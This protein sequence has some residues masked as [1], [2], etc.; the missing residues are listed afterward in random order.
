MKIYKSVL[1]K[2]DTKTRRGKKMSKEISAVLNMRK[3]KTFVGGFNVLAHNLRLKLMTNLKENINQNLSHFNVYID[4]KDKEDFNTRYN[5]KI[6]NANLKRKIQKNASRIIEFVF[7]FSHLYSEGWQKIPALKKK[8]DN[9]FKDCIEFIHSEYGDIIV[10]STIHYD[11]F[12]PH[13]HI[14]CIPLIQIKNGEGL[15]FSSSEFMGGRFGMKNLH[16]NFHKKVGKNYGLARGVEDSITS[17]SDLKRYKAIE[18]KKLNE[19]EET[20]RA[21]KKELDNIEIHRREIE[22]N[23]TASEHLR[24]R[25]V[26]IHSDNFKRTATLIKKEEEFKKFEKLVSGQTPDIPILKPKMNE[27][28]SIS[29]RNKVQE[30]VNSAFKGIFSA[31]KTLQKKYTTLLENFNKLMIL[32]EQI[33]KRADKAEKDLAEKPINEILA[34]RN[35]AKKPEQGRRNASCHS[36]S[37]Y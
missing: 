21:I 15:K 30:T 8:L 36:G 11:E 4:A 33:K 35:M 22:S 10:S 28:D 1:Y 20:Q 19:M 24:N 9:Y 13:I 5:E 2:T 18:E 37:S 29:W 12:T 23:K 26:S 14:M 27:K 6:K 16:T 34:I 7:S 25:M 31:Y 32:N 3:V 17:H